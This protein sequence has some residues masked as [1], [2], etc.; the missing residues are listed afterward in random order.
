M[1]ILDLFLKEQSQ[2]QFASDETMYLYMVLF[3]AGNSE[4]A[5]DEHA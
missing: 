4:E 5:K 2:P 1:S 3:L